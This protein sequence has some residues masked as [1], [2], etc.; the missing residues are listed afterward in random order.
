ML[1]LPQPNVFGGQA[2]D[3]TFGVNNASSSTAGSNVNANEMIQV[4][5]QVLAR[6][7]GRLTGALTGRAAIRQ[8]GHDADAVWYVGTRWD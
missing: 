6:V 5:L 8:R 3:I 1:W 4:Y 2:H 7:S